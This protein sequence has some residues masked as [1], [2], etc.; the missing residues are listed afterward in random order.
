M[1][2]LEKIENLIQRFEADPGLSPLDAERLIA[3]VFAFCGF[4][5]SHTGGISDRGIDV[6]FSTDING[7]NQRFAVQ[8]KR[9]TRPLGKIEVQKLVGASLAAKEF[10]RWLFLATTGFSQGAHEYIRQAG[11]TN[12]DL[13][14]AQDLRQWIHRHQERTSPEAKTASAFI[15]DA[16]KALGMLVAKN[17]AQLFELEWRDLERV[18]R[19]VFEG[20]GFDTVLTRSAKDGGFDLQLTTRNDG[21]RLVYLVEVKHWTA[22]SR[23][24]IN[25]LKHFIDVVAREAADGG[26]LLSSSGFSKTLYEGRTEIDCTTVRTGESEKIISLIQNYY[27]LETQIWIKEQSL[28]ALLFEDTQG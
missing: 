25:V 19:E 3:D 1:A 18:L 14:S 24:G 15:R 10:D 5:T 21:S 28:P 2:D 26:L 8:V 12:F 4:S 20:L 6:A 16:M 23:P 22:P 11:V 9:T 17:P 27:K 13:L 7:V